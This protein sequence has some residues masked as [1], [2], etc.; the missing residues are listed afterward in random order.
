MEA[1][2]FTRVS[3]SSLVNGLLT[4]DNHGLGSG[5]RLKATEAKN[6]PKPVKVALRVKENIARNPD[7]LLQ[8]I[9]Q[10]NPGLRTEYWRA[11]DKQSEP[12]GLRFILLINRDSYNIIKR[13]GYKILTGLLEGMIKVLHDPEAQHQEEAVADTASLASGSEGKEDDTPIPS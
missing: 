10:L 13:T 7:E 9:K 3:T 2:V 12:K 8:W 6:L 5:G 11:L 4:I 1:H